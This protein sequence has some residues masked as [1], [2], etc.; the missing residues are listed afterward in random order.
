LMKIFCIG[1]IIELRFSIV[2]TLSWYSTL[3]HLKDWGIQQEF[4]MKIFCIGSI[5]T[6]VLNRSLSVLL[7]LFSLKRVLVPCSQFDSISIRISGFSL[8]YL[9]YSRFIMIVINVVNGPL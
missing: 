6:A 8:T 4:S 9:C 2:L 3:E 1:S 7:F 5:R